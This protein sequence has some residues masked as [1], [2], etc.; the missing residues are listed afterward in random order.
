MRRPFHGQDG[1]LNGRLMSAHRTPNAGG[2]CIKHIT[3]SQ[4]RC[5]PRGRLMA[6]PQ[7]DAVKAKLCGSQT[8]DTVE[9]GLQGRLDPGYSAAK[10]GCMLR[11]RQ[12]GPSECLRQHTACRGEPGLGCSVIQDTWDGI[13]SAAVC[14]SCQH[15][16]A[17]LRFAVIAC[18][19]A[20]GVAWPS[21]R[22]TLRT[23]S[24]CEQYFV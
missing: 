8:E 6:R 14:R 21:S 2:I 10:L 16:D 17:R 5:P 4:L 3:G 7:L 24:A 12:C 19:A 22:P 11:N 13:S 18:P 15:M 20:V 1:E 23:T 9:A